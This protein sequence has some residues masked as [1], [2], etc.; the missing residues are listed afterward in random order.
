[1]SHICQTP[2]EPRHLTEVTLTLRAG[3]GERMWG[4]SSQRRAVLLLSTA[5]PHHASYYCR[6]HLSWKQVRSGGPSELPRLVT[7]LLSWTGRL[8]SLSLGLPT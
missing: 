4:P 5:L 1:M 8:A 3:D 7:A 6:A 2:E